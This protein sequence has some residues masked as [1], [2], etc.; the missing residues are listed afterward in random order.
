MRLIE[1]QTLAGLE[2]NVTTFL[3]FLEQRGILDS[4]MVIFTSD[5]GY[6]KGEHQLE[7]KQIAQEESIRVPL[8]IRY[9]YWFPAGTVV[10]NEMAANIDIPLTML[11]AAGIP[12]HL[13][14]MALSLKKLYDQT[15][16]RNYFF[17]E[18]AGESGSPTIRAIRSNQYK[19]VKHYC[20]NVTEEFYDLATDPKENVNLI[21][22]A[23]FNSLIS[24]YRFKLDSFRTAV[25]DYTP[26]MWGVH[27]VIRNSPR[28]GDD[29]H[30]SVNDRILRLWP[31]P[32]TDYFLVNFNEAGN[33]EDIIIDVTNVLG[34]RVYYKEIRATD[35]PECL[36]TLR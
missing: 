7:A 1:F 35:V 31:N 4:T 36:G 8:F 19:Y 9:P 34:Q 18:Y 13:E 10:T 16:Q 20:T 32:A 12:E 5:N 21:N 11:H 28:K 3:S 26:V 24:S 22:N 27:L 30:E 2:D 17:Y 15:V 33:S 29:E 6:L 14:W 25:G 23:S